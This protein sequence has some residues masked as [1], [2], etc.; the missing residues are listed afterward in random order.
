MEKKGFMGRLKILSRPTGKPQWKLAAKSIILI[1]LA[2]F[3]AKFLSFDKGIGAILSIT[4]LASIIIDLPLPLRKVVPL[5]L[6]GFLMTFLAFISAYLALSSLPVFLFFTVIWAFFSLSLYIFGET[7]GIFGF[8]IFISYFVAVVMVNRE[9]SALEWGLYV[10]L[11]YLVSSIL[12]I[13][14]IIGRKRNILKMVSS[15]FV[16]DTSLEKVLYMRTNLSGVPLDERDYVLFHLGEYLAGFRSYSKLVLSRLSG[17]SKELFQSFLDSVNEA[18]LEIASSITGQQKTVS[19]EMVDERIDN[20][21]KYLDSRD[22]NSNTLIEISK[23]I[24]FLL[25]RSDELL[26]AK[27]PSHRKKKIS[28]PGNSLKEVLRANFNLKNMY[29]RHALR[30]SLAMTLGLLAVYLS[31]DRDA[32]W[33]TMGILIIIKPDVTSTLN[34]ILVR[35][36][37]NAAA[38]LLAILMGFL[39]PH[40]LLLVI[41]F[42]MLFFFRAFYP[43][44]MGLSVMALSVF[45]VLIWPT[46]SVWENALARIMDISLGAIIA[47][48]CAYAI[49]PSRVRVNLPQQMA[50]TIRSNK[51]YAEAVLPSSGKTYRH[52]KA[53]AAFR[54]YMLEEKNLESAIKKVEDTFD[55]VEDDVLIYNELFA[56]NRK[57]AAD[58]FAV[59]TL[60]ES[61]GSIPDF[62]LS[63][64]QLSNALSEMALS[65]DKN[66]ILPKATINKFSHS[67]KPDPQIK[68]GDVNRSLEN[69]LNWIIS[70]VKYL[71]EVV[72]SAIKLGALKRYRNM[73]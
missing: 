2:A 60:I 17:K 50:R 10:V 69:Y 1:F 54:D 20:L 44:Y 28:Q 27:Y 26:L 19:L 63:K 71:Q 57:L 16:P 37:F 38:I 34:N 31:H 64:E 29:I 22:P 23:E 52:Q 4:L 30:F 48:I 67:L 68:I 25:K 61:S 7:A 39:F 43:H 70:D 3:V 72:E 51:K 59:A 8:M 45:V 12:F 41:A 53:S 35:V 66:V 24:K 33:I 56:A 13:P 46:G 18:S 73:T 40:E 58:I 65:V 6:I 15:P 11:A 32:I 49:L 36:S 9:A 62:T 14:K 42:L 47:F 21:K 5:A 55:D